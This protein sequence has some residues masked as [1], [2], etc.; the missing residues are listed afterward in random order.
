MNNNRFVPWFQ[1]FFTLYFCQNYPSLSNRFQKFNQ[2]VP[3]GESKLIRY[4]S[5]QLLLWLCQQVSCLKLKN[6]LIIAFINLFG[7]PCIR[8]NRCK[9]RQFQSLE[10]VTMSLSAP[11]ILVAQNQQFLPNLTGTVNWDLNFTCGNS[12]KRITFSNICD[13]VKV[14][15]KCWFVKFAGLSFPEDW[16]KG[17]ICVVEWPLGEISTCVLQVQIPQATQRVFSWLLDWSSPMQSSKAN[18]FR[19]ESPFGNSA[20]FKQLDWIAIVRFRSAFLN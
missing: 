9:S 6:L 16:F 19:P 10:Q 2:F 5:F 3:E 1:T 17:Q 11:T 14:H 12:I 7:F 18:H 13:S 20:S 8:E 4:P 15:K